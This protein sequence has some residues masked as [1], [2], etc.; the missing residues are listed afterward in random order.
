MSQHGGELSSLAQSRAKES[1][2]LL[3]EAVGC[4][5]RIVA[6]GWWGGERQE[7][8]VKAENGDKMKEKRGGIEEIQKRK[9]KTKR[10]LYKES[11]NES[12]I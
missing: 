7:N 3:Y 6:L 2:D 12:L 4:Q 8:N 10:F 11:A 5:E 1:R 9:R